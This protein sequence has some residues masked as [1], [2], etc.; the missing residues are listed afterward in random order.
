ME[1]ERQICQTKKHALK[2]ATDELAKN[3]ETIKN[4]SRELENVQK[5]IDWRT[6][7]LLRQEK[8]VARLEA[9]NQKFLNVMKLLEI[10]HDS[11]KGKYQEFNGTVQTLKKSLENLDEKYSKSKLKLTDKILPKILHS[12]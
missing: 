8:D 11:Y 2:I 3:T 5:K 6:V 12:I 10:D 4:Q 9:E 1:A 7:V